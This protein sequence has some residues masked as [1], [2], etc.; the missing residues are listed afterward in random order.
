MTKNLALSAV[1]ALVVSLAIGFAFPKQVQQVVQQ[2]GSVVS[3]QALQSPVCVDGMCTYTQTVAISN[4]WAGGTGTTTPC[5]FKLPSATTTLE[6][7]VIQINTATST[8]INFSLGSTT[9]AFATGTTNALIGS[10][11]NAGS[12]VKLAVAASQQRTLT[13]R[14]V[15]DTGVAGPGAF[16]V[17]G[18]QGGPGVPDMGFQI[19]GRCIIKYSTTG[20]NGAN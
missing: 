10:N 12:V 18:A 14:P 9:S 3:S 20:I 15:L 11:A 7:L 16:W 1:V 8:A 4:T 17:V 2:L 5:A 19:G 13:F 6:S